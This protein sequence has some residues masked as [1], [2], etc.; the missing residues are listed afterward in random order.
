MLLPLGATAQTDR[1][2]TLQAART[3]SVS[4]G[5]QTSQHLVSSDKTVTIK[6]KDGQL[7]V[8]GRDTLDM[9]SAR[10]RLSV[11]PR[12]A[13]DEDS[14][15]WTGS[16]SMTAGLLAFRRTLSVGRWNS[17]VVPFDLTAYQLR[18][19]FGADVRLAA[20]NDV[21]ADGDGSVRVDFK[22]VGLSDDN[23]L[24]VSAN[25]HYLIMPSREPDIAEGTQTSVT[26]GSAKVY[27]PVYAI[28]GVSMESG[29]N[30]R[31]QSLRSDD[32]SAT[33]RVR[34]TYATTEVPIGSNPRYV[35]GDEG[36]YS[37]IAEATTLKAFRSYVEDASSA[38]HVRLAFTIDGVDEGLSPE[39]T[40]IEG[41]QLARSAST[42]DGCYDL[43]GRRL[44][45]PQR[46]GLY[47]VN[48]KKLYIK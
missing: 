19:A 14:A 32:K 33:V 38:D 1:I 2:N 6:F 40:A 41:L 7:I 36:R 15:T 45:A 5:K 48:G 42:T 17:L 13:V 35:L 34:G 26:Y 44:R 8:G 24:A 30:A 9:S 12:F 16:Y 37:P 43:Q 20:L 4:N 31:Y 29:Q 23:A 10:L 39:A 22:S 47:I 27:G 28:A 25:Q 3:L 21:T 11:P 18:D 46:P